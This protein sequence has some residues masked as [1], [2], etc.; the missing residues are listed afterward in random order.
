MFFQGA[1]EHICLAHAYCHD[2]ASCSSF[3]ISLRGF[4]KKNARLRPK[5][6][7]LR[8]PNKKANLALAID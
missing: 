5:S 2:K 8:L 4:G 7:A 6:R 1:N 3:V